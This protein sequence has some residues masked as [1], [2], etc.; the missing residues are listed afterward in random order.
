M[1]KR[2]VPNISNGLQ[3]NPLATKKTSNGINTIRWNSL[4]YQLGRL[5]EV[6]VLDLYPVVD[7]LRKIL[8]RGRGREGHRIILAKTHTPSD[9]RCGDPGARPDLVG[10]S[11][12][13][14]RGRSAEAIN[15]IRLSNTFHSQIFTETILI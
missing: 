15:Q 3:R 11:E 1:L 7:N 12:P 13:K 4:S 6:E 10:R 2:H 8:L 14:P 5:D 9:Y